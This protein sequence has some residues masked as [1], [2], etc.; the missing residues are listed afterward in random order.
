MVAILDATGGVHVEDV[1]LAMQMLSN[2]NE[3]CCSVEIRSQ[4]ARNGTRAL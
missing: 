2:V 1:L 4:F 3:L